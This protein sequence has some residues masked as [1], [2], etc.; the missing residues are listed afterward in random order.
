MKTKYHQKR[1]RENII[2]NMKLIHK[3]KIVRTI[4]NDDIVPDQ[5]FLGY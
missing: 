1:E 4:I 5:V 2:E 3:I